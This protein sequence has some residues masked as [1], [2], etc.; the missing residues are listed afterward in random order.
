VTVATFLAILRDRRGI[1]ATEHGILGMIVIAALAAIAP[2][3]GG[4]LLPVFDV[5]N[6]VIQSLP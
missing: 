5:I 4:S 6:G 3:L 2:Q 1:S